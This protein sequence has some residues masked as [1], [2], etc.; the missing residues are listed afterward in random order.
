[1][2]ADRLDRTRAVTARLVAC[3]ASVSVRFS[4]RSRHFS[5]FS[6]AKI[7]A[8]A[9]KVRDGGGERREGNV[10]PF[11]SPV[12][13]FFA[14]APIFARLKNEKCLERAE[15]LTE[16]LATQATR[17]AKRDPTNRKSVRARLRNIQ[18]ERYEGG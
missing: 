2:S 8:S 12:T 10:S 16:T 9:K 3:V 7:G 14:L 5:F 6:R 15:N 18:V 11:P 4:A 13:H 1:M 17:L